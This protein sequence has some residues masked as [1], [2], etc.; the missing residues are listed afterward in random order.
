MN[1]VYNILIISLADYETYYRAGG[2]QGCSGYSPNDKPESSDEAAHKNQS[3]I[4]KA[5]LLK[6]QLTLPQIT[7]D[8]SALR[9]IMRLRGYSLMTNVL[10]DYES[11]LE[12]ITSVCQ[13]QVLF[14]QLINDRASRWNV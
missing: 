4:P 14:Y 2:P 5:I 1:A 13:P 3:K 11:D 12:M 9:Q 8:A 6:S 10:E 7:E